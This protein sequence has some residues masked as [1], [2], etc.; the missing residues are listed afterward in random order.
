MA[1]SKDLHLYKY[2]WDLA[3]LRPYRQ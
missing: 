1:I 2:T 3:K